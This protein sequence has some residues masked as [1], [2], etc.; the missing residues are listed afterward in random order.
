MSSGNPS[1]V[2]CVCQPALGAGH[3]P[4][5]LVSVR[6]AEQNYPNS[7]LFYFR[8]RKENKGLNST[9]EGKTVH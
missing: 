4:L 9:L 6:D 1:R 5:K 8:G 3:G 2:R 7:F